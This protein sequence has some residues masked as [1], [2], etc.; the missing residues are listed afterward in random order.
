MQKLIAEVE[1]LV[2]AKVLAWMASRTLTDVASLTWVQ[3]VMLA[4]ARAMA[5]SV[6]DAWK[7]ALVQLAQ[8]VRQC[9]RCGRPRK[10]KWRSS[11]PLRV[12]V[13]GFCIEL[14]KLYLECGHC[15]AA[16]VSIIRLLTGL[17]SGEA[18]VQLRLAAAYCASEQSYG[19]AHRDLEVHYGQAI[20]RTK[21]RRIALE[22]EQEA[23]LYAEAGRRQ[24]LKPIEGEARTTG[25]PL[26]LV[27]GDG[28]KVRT[29]Q[30]VHCE[31]GDPRHGERTPKRG[32]PRRRRPI[33]WREVITMDVRQ[34]QETEATALDVLVPVLAAEGER[35]RRMLAL[36]GR[37]GLGDN[38]LVVGLGD[39]GS[40]LAPSFGEA[41]F[42]YRGSWWNADWKHTRDYVDAV[43]KVLKKTC[44][45]AS[46]TEAMKDAIWDHDKALC[47][48]LLTQARAQR[49]KVLPRE[50]EKCPVGAL[51]T[52]LTNNWKHMRFK[53]LKAMG[54][55]FVSARAEAQV[56]DRT[57]GR[58]S[59]AGAW[60]LE[61][62]EPKATLRAIIAD[63]RWAAFREHLTRK[64]RTDFEQ[65]LLERLRQ[66]VEDGRLSPDQLRIL[67]VSADVED[68]AA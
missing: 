15:D 39:M 33:S 43:P 44:D 10:C 5:V 9:P 51:K 62:V 64:S 66:A 60:R 11:Q 38:T 42:A 41:F 4:V 28:G 16:S 50:L 13:L 23:M 47:D 14:P 36:A 21:L 55:P 46:W 61:N 67:G 45:G 25:V 52:Y 27:E 2:K 26:L 18:S 22:V 40:E 34:P 17:A 48:E 12:E 68:L 6:G 35:A 54:L 30:L 8:G 65:A 56:R 32:L 63:G 49:V 59:V 19:D 20:E 1:G 58:F 53:Q 3:E 7:G 31:E 57:K 37:K 24:A 29:G